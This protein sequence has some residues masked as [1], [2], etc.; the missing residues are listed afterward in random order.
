M[1]TRLRPRGPAAQRLKLAGSIVL[2]IVIFAILGS[3]IDGEAVAAAI[4]AM[5]WLELATIAAVTLWNFVT[6][7]ALWVAVTPGLSWPRAAVLAQSGTALTNTVPGGS[8][9]GV[10]LIYAMLD[11]WGFPR[12]R[13]TL[14]VLVSGL[15]NSFIK[16]GM[17]ALALGLLALQGDPSAGRATSGVIA[18]VLLGVAVGLLVATLRSDRI[19]ARVGALAGR[20]ATRVRALVRKGPVGDWSVSLVAFSGRVNELLRARWAWI[21]L[22][23]LVSHLSLYLVL[24]VTL[25]HVGVGDTVV[26]WV[27]VLSVFAF[28]RLVT[29]VRFTPG[30]AGVV[31]AVLIAGLVAAGGPVAE[32]TAAV[33]VFRALTWL[34][35]V[36][37]GAATYLAWRLQIRRRARVR[38]PHP[39]S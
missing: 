34:L 35:P 33:L 25:R 38:V 21:T 17:P 14:A 5:T 2:A 31:E 12:D 32:V 27:E 4:R 9:I 8:G 13:S 10:G 15:W 26:G 29:M 23:A 39:Q 3:R 18:L 11:S 16:L 22:A 20:A 7:W 1:P 36:P 19:A 28:A 6:Y 24:L 30:G 37:I